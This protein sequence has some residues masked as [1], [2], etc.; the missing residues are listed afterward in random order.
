MS[1]PQFEQVHDRVYRL[2]TPFEGGG[3]VNLYLI[4]GSRTAIVDSGVLGTPTNFVAPA[5]EAL[6]LTLGDVD[7]LLN[8][9]GHMDHLGGNSEL[10]DA[11]AEIALHRADAPRASSNKLHVEKAA[12]GMKALGLEALL[13]QREAFLLRLLGREVGVDRVLDDGDVVDLGSDVRLQVVATPGHTPGSVCYWWEA[14]GLLITGDSVQARGSRAGGL[15]VIEEPA[16][17]PASLERVRSVDP[18][19]LLMAHNFRGS[20]GVLGPVA[21]GP[22]IADVLRESLSTHQALADAF[23]RAVA[24]APNAGGGEIAR[25]VVAALRDTLGLE[26]EPGVGVPSSGTTTLPSYLRAASA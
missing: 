17:Y 2:P 6:G 8:S 14:A 22:R 16:S 9:H 7:L 18:S 26:D 10:K 24:E 15:P 3:L 25:R 13:P 20:A 23:K 21:S 11:G 5:L 4:R 1:A 12:E 19:T